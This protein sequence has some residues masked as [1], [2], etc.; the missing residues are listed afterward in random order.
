MRTELGIL[1]LGPKAFFATA[2]ARER[3]LFADAILA[4]PENPDIPSI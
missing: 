4:S 2:S 1:R 3:R